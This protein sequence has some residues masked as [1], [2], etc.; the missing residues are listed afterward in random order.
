MSSRHKFSSQ[1]PSSRENFFLSAPQL[2]AG[3]EREE[4][5]R[6][7]SLRERD[8]FLWEEGERERIFSPGAPRGAPGS[9]QQEPGA[10]PGPRGPDS[11][12]L[13]PPGG[14]L[15]PRGPG[16]TTNKRVFWGLY[17][18]SNVR[19]GQVLTSIP[20]KYGP[21]L[22]VDFGPL[23]SGPFS[24]P[25]GPKFMKNHEISWNLSTPEPP[26]SPGPQEPKSGPGAPGA[27]RSPSE[28]LW[29]P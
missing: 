17:S 24:F 9:P 20:T 1:P 14:I 28:P 27:L 5:E 18:S 25:G 23:K 29:S 7:F 6:I 15:A 2:R 3:Q 13:V 21:I 16:R 4:R 11:V 8:F 12:Q 19:F 10:G 22:E 26:G